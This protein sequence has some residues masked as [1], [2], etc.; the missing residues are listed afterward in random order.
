MKWYSFVPENLE[1]CKIIYDRKCPPNNSVYE[2]W[3]T[4][5]LENDGA[6]I[7]FIEY[8]FYDKDPDGVR[9]AYDC[10]YDSIYNITVDTSK[11]D[12]QKLFAL[13]ITKDS[14]II[15]G[16]DIDIKQSKV[17]YIFTEPYNF[18]NNLLLRI[19]NQIENDSQ[20]AKE[21]IEQNLLVNKNSSCLV[22]LNDRM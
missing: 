2:E 4:V 5:G 1:K 11:A 8:D 18:D 22:I 3:T 16:F 6:Q 13:T 7:T 12:K 10:V 15:E 21:I 14:S 17:I 19:S 20:N 9:E